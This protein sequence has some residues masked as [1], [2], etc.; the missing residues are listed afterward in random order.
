MK[1]TL[2]ITGLGLIG[3]LLPTALGS[4]GGN[5]DGKLTTD[6]IGLGRTS[7]ADTCSL[8][9][10]FPTGGPRRLRDSVRVFIAQQ[11]DSLYV[12][13]GDTKPYEQVW[14]EGV[15]KNGR[16]LAE[17]YVDINLRE[18]KRLRGDEFP[19]QLGLE[20]SLHLYKIDET[21]DFVTYLS[22]AYSYTGGAHGSGYQAGTTFRKRDGKRL[23]MV[24]DTTKT[25][26]MQQL[27]REGIVRYFRDM[28]ENEL[29]EHDIISHLYIENGVVPLPKSQPYLTKD[30]V[31]FLYGQYEIGP[32][33]LGMPVFR[34]PYADVERFLTPE[35][36]DLVPQDQA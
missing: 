10:D 6:S 27:L 31:V 26:E 8:E 12:T 30:G 3:M 35:A 34:A 4:C 33:V 22:D 1:I 2:I 19:E 9:I 23:N 28:G 17:K 15:P 32:Y 36:A 29:S 5:T 16:V 13:M 20:Q 24:V 7:G 25:A 21:T 14:T 11:L 18:L